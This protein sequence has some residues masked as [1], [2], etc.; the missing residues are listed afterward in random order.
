[1]KKNHSERNYISTSKRIQSWQDISDAIREARDTFDMTAHD[2]RDNNSRNKV[3]TL[4]VTAYEIA[5]SES[6]YCQM[7]SYD[8][9]FI[10]SLKTILSR[11]KN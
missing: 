6:S 5:K 4:L 10:P 8:G 2:A 9:C 1:M 11:A 3:W 7:E